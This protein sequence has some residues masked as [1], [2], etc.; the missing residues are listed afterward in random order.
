MSDGFSKTLT[1]EII[2]KCENSFASSIK[3]CML[4]HYFIE[5]ILNNL[6]GSERIF[7]LSLYFGGRISF[8]K[9]PHLIFGRQ[10]LT[11]YFTYHHFDRYFVLMLATFNDL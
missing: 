8:I 6:S 1:L 9:P 7:G 3:I 10:N 5:I 11:L 4:F 2:I